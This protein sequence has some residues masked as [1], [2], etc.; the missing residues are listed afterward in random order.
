MTVHLLRAAGGFLI[1]LSALQLC[2]AAA[3]AA[4]ISWWQRTPGPGAATS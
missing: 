2:A 1:V 3:V 4:M